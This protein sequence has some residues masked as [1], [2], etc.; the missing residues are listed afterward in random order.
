M[1]SLAFNANNR[2]LCWTSFIFPAAFMNHLN[3]R[4]SWMLYAICVGLQSVKHK[5]LRDF[6]F[7]SKQS[8]RTGICEYWTRN[9]LGY[10][11]FLILFGKKLIKVKLFISTINKAKISYWHFIILLYYYSLH[12]C[13]I[14]S[15]PPSCKSE[16]DHDMVSLWN[17]IIT[18]RFV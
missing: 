13:Q 8:Y 12:T 7:T 3:L 16:C 17:S 18:R 11:L 15:K 5:F 10:Y 9:R 14:C 1:F 4:Y 2:K 6:C